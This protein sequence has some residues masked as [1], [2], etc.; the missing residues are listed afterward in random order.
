MTS[1]HQA[2]QALGARLRE[3]RR[4]ADLTGRQLAELLAWP[5]SKVSKLETGKQTPSDADITSWTE[6]TGASAEK[7]LALLASLHTLESRHAEWERVLRGGMSHHQSEWGDAE[8]RAGLLRVFEPVYIPGLLQTAEYARGRMAE[9]IAMH[10]LPNDIGEAV[11]ARMARQ[12]VLYDPGKRFQFVITEAALRYRLCP[13]E[14]MVP[15]LDRLVAASTLP[16]VR[17]GVIGFETTLV[18]A[19]KHG[20]W[21]FD[22]NL[23][24]VETFTAELHLAQPPE[25]ER[26][27]QVFR[28]LAGIASYGQ[29]ARALLMKVMEDLSRSLPVG[30]TSAEE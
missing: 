5:H 9:G 27:A 21:I 4:A 11:Q 28:S 2:R 13:P 29:A 12:Q 20:F 10:N 8:R 22:N 18:T 26:Y 1:V 23:V 30:E 25:I 6:A 16:N 17:L 24:M 14:V 7:R 3:L 15:Q 19:P